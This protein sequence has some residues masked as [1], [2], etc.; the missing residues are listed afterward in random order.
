MRW[1]L[2]MSCW[3]V[4]CPSPGEKGQRGD[5][6]ETWYFC[7]AR[8]ENSTCYEYLGG[9]NETTCLDASLQEGRCGDLDETALEVCVFVEDGQ[10]SDDVEFQLYFYGG[11]EAPFLWD[12]PA[13]REAWCGD[14][15]GTLA[16]VP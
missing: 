7:D 3:L 14:L 9:P 1:T 2:W 11:G 8:S 16:P 13:N 10:K 5:A 15:E 12:E 4:G 6:G